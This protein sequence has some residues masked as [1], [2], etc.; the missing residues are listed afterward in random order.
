MGHRTE[1]YEQMPEAVVV[2]PV[3]VREEIRAR[4]VEETLGQN[5]AQSG[6][7]EAFVNRFGNEYDRPTHG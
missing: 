1:Q 3:V 2:G 7:R 5:A 4:G 6:K